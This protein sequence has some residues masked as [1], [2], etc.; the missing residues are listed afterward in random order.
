VS[1]LAGLNERLRR[2][3]SSPLFWILCGAALLR[4]VGLFWGLPAADGWDDDG[5]A[6]RNFLV[7]I[8]QTY[9]PGSYFTYPPFHMFILAV[10]T[11]PGWIAALLDARSLTPH[12]VIAEMIQVPY[13]T[14]FAVVARAVSAAMSVGTIYLI[15]KITETVGGRRAGLF[16]AAACAL[17]AAL[18]Y[19]G[20]VTNLDGPYLFWA[21]LSIWGCMRVITEHEPKHIRW[22]ALAAAAAVATKDQAYAVFLLSVP[23]GLLMWVALDSWPRQHA[24]TLIVT[25]LVW[26]G[27]ALVALLA[28]DGALTNPSG[29]ADRIAFLTGPASRDYAQYQSDWVGRITLLRDMWVYFPRYYPSAAILLAALGLAIHASRW[30]QDLARFVAGLLPLLAIISFTVAF[31]FVALRN[32]P[33]FFLPQSI[34]LAVYIGIAVDKLVFL[35][36]PQVR[37]AMRGLVLALA[38]YAFYQCGGIVAAF[39]ADPRYDAEQWL[40]AHAHKGDMIEAYG[41]NVYLPRFPKGAIVTRVSQKPLNRRNPLPNVTEVRQPYGELAARRPRFIVFNAFSARDFLEADT[42]ALGAGR[43][44]PKVEQASYK[45]AAARAYFRAL[46]AGRFP[47]RLVHKS[48]Y[49]PGFWPP[50]N[51]YESLAQTIFLFER[52]S[53]TGSPRLP[54]TSRSGDKTKDTGIIMRKVT[55]PGDLRNHVQADKT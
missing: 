25:L 52:V 4:T 44:A 42:A 37:W 17:N 33:R 5:I 29:F 34:F 46:F 19:Y 8:A 40:R 41:L 27:V 35:S 24:R 13:M 50:L 47:Y 48:V 1:T 23:L 39:A 26:T 7:G 9:T 22:A 43:V 18:T 38:V 32:E 11:A 3:A 45:N 12:D 21:A 10:L 14:F 20:Q 53:I 49:S 16:A 55:R 36:P 54:R 2:L 51:A 30:R 28:I 31:N 15:G 6:P